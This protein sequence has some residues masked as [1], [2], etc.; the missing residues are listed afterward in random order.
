LNLLSQFPGW[1][2]DQNNGAVAWVKKQTCKN[3]WNRR[4]LYKL[5]QKCVMKRKRKLI[6]VRKYQITEN[7]LNTSFQIRLMIDVYDSW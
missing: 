2:Q 7:S 6:Y 3:S 4:E 1:R 5:S